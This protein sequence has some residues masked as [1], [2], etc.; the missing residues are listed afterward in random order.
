MKGY[1]CVL[2]YNTDLFEP[3]TIERMFAHY[4]RI[5][6]W[7]VSKPAKGIDEF[8]LLTEAERQ[9]IL[10]EW[11]DTVTVYPSRKMYPSTLLKNK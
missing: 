6:E 11:N 2:E 8:D 1:V 4:E 7:M 9:Q 3:E 5:L 10:V